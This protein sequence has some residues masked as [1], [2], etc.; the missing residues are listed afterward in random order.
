MN[1]LPCSYSPN[2]LI[3]ISFS[4]FQHALPPFIALA[5]LQLS[6]GG[7]ARITSG[8]S[9]PSSVSHSA[10]GLCSILTARSWLIHASPIPIDVIVCC[11][12]YSRYIHLPLD[13]SSRCHHQTAP[14]YAFY[15]TSPCSHSSHRAF[16]FNLPLLCAI[17]SF[18]RS[19][20]VHHIQVATLNNAA[21]A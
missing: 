21:R 8:L 13:D 15:A 16:N 7:L 4:C 10:F 3:V 17:C 6:Q 2:R 5:T 9:S 18:H 20:S 12:P 19:L 14:I 1:L 11:P